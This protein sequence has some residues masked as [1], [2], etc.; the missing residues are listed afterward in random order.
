MKIHFDFI[1]DEEDA[2]NMVDCIMNRG[3]EMLEYY[4]TAVV[5]KNEPMM[6][7]YRTKADYFFG[8]VHLMSNRK[9]IE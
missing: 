4:N 2:Q 6:K 1:V 9:E 7:Y 3:G 5:G 8:L